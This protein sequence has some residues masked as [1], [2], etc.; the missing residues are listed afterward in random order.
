M[1]T[2]FF[3]GNAVTSFDSAAE[4]DTAAFDRFHHAMMVAGVWLAPSQIEAAVISTAQGDRKID[5]I[6]TTAKSA[7]ER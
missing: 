3:I 6:L 5:H 4:S 2:W 1:F 7:L